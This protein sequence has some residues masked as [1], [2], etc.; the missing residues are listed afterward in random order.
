MLKATTITARNKR[1][2]NHLIS[3]KDVLTKAAHIRTSSGVTSRPI[4][5][6]YPLDVS[7]DS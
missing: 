1:H 2:Q 5:K 7:S 3:G 4:V 6:L